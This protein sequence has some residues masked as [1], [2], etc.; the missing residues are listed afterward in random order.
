MN[1]IFTFLMFDSIEDKSIINLVWN[2]SVWN[3]QSVLLL[4]N[5]L[6]SLI[7]LFEFFIHNNAL[8][9]TP[10]IISFNN[11]HIKRSKNYKNMF[12]QKFPNQYC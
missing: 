4:E 1:I 7:T 5:Y 6:N 2:G 12:A 11:N 8:L 9:L 10:I 3:S